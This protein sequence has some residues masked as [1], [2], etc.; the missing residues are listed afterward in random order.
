[1]QDAELESAKMELRKTVKAILK[2]MDDESRESLSHRSVENLMALPGYG[3]ADIIL[4]FLSMREEVQTASL[5][6]QGF[7]EAKVVAVPR[8]GLTAEK[9]DFLEFIPLPSDYTGWPLDRFGIPEPPKDARMLSLEELGR[10]RV[11]I[12]VPGL[13]FDLFGG[14]MGRGK[15]YYD[16]FLAMARAAAAQYGGSL[17]VCGLCFES[18]IVEVVPM[19]PWDQRVDYLATETGLRKIDN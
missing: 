12:A 5:V 9:G 14:R 2:A 8:I 11:V 3:M 6:D 18:Q 7:E 10:S 15:G 16:R 1:M 19:E 13:A 17:A 4:A